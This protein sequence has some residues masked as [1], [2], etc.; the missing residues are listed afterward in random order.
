MVI[1]VKSGV[2]NEYEVKHPPILYLQVWDN[3]FI[4]K[5]EFLGMLE[6]NLSNFPEPCTNRRF[7]TL[8]NEFGGI[9][10]PEPLARLH[11]I[12]HRRRPPV[13]LFAKKRVRGW[14]PLHGQIDQMSKDK[15]LKE[16]MRSQ[17]V[18]GMFQ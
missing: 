3:D 6:L 15:R 16:Q 11:A 12:A 5:N 17:T 18:S 4:T 13:N 8:T 1:K 9:K 14:F 7:C 10:L 2:L